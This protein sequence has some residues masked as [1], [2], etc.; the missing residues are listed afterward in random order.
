MDVNVGPL[1]RKG[2]V[3]RK[4]RK[5]MLSSTVS[6]PKKSQPSS[7]SSTPRKYT[8]RWL[9]ESKAYQC[10]GC[11]SAIRVPGDVPQAPHDVVAATKEYRS[12]TKDGKLQVCYGPTH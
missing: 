7:S 4:R 10:Y 2:S 3:V 5:K 11:N 6:A 12:F 1:G 9:S 8:L